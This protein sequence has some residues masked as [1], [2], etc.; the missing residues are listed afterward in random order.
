MSHNNRKELTGVIVPMLVPFKKNGLL[1]EKATREIVIYL[2]KRVHGFFI[3]GSFGSGPLLSIDERKRILEISVEEIGDEAAISNNIGAVSTRD[4][5]E[6]GKHSEDLGISA[7]ASTVPY[8]YRHGEKN[9]ENFFETLLKEIKL[10]LWFYN[11]PNTTMFNISTYLL[12][13]LY[14][15]GICGIKDS[16]FDIINFY[17]YI[18]EIKVNNFHFTIGTEA[19][20]LPA[21]VI[22]CDG[23][24]SAVS[25][26]FPEKVVELWDSVVAGDMSRASKLQIQLIAIRGILKRESSHVSSAIIQ[27]IL[28][29][30]GINSGYAR[31]PFLDIDDDYYKKVVEDF[32]KI[33]IKLN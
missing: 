13:R 3:N 12:K 10:P 18:Y 31:P 6:L 26:C 5:L 24:I 16:S 8:Y 28:R 9:I 27:R 32:K 4:A 19:L 25:N 30:K 7:V 17:N 1:D 29:G 20:L 22:R 33:G 21:A 23:C 14:K 15:K 2:K 11:N